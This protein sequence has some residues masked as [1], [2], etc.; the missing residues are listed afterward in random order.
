M[1]NRRLSP[2][3]KAA[4]QLAVSCQSST[5]T[6][7]SAVPRISHV[8]LFLVVYQELVHSSPVLLQSSVHWHLP[9]AIHECAA[10][11]LPKNMKYKN[12]KQSKWKNMHLSSNVLYR[13][14]QAML[15]LSVSLQLPLDSPII[16]V[17]LCQILCWSSNWV[18]TNTTGTRQLAI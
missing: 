12:R 10:A 15:V 6:H 2:V 4:H 1:T 5:A 11:I 17:V 9:E 13:S 8:A 18:T 14:T 16:P 7:H 3:A